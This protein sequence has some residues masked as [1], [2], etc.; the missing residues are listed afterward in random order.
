MK[1][2]GHLVLILLFACWGCSTP[3]TAREKG[4]LIGYGVGS[5]VGAGAG[6]AAGNPALGALAG[7]PVGAVT[8]AAVASS[9]SYERE[10]KDLQERVGRQEE[11]LRELRESVHTLG[12]REFLEP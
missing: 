7:G 8:G 4:G 6:Y 1:R 2:H 11:E 3:L 5:G 10:I 9:W 12:R